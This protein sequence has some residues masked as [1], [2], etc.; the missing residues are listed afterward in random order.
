MRGAYIII[1]GL[2]GCFGDSITAF[3]EGLEPLEELLFEPIS[4]LDGVPDEGMELVTGRRDDGVLWGHL[5]GFVHAPLSEVWLA[6]QHPDVVVDRRRVHTYTP[7]LNVEEDYDFS[8]AIDQVVRD[9]ITV[10]YT[11]TWRH[12][13]VGEPEQPSK[14]AMRWQ[15][16]SG[17][18]LIEIL[19]GSVVLL[20]TP[21]EDITE[22]QSIEHLKA[23]LTSTDEIEGLLT[24][25]WHD[26]LDFAHGRELQA[27][28]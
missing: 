13:A 25:V 2:A 16:T 3:P 28:D 21:I 7:R 12:G 8:M 24:D 1:V 19:Q 9:I 27:F 22:V 15:K 17:S 26:T 20:P 11:L 18:N 14:V 5:R 4:L 6:Y 10:E 23:P